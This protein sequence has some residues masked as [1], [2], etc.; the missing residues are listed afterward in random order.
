VTRDTILAAITAERDRQERLWAG[1]HK[2]GYGSCAGDG[3]A[4]P[5]KITILT[6]EVG[7]VARAFLD[8]KD[9]DLRTELIQVAAVAIAMLEGMQ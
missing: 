2:H 5:V 7:E 6:E 8:G 3:V 1:R 4:M 9:D